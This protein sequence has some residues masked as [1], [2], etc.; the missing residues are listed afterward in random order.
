MRS[1]PIPIARGRRPR[2]RIPPTFFHDPVGVASVLFPSKKIC[3]HLRLDS[4]FF[5]PRYS[6]FDLPV[7]EALW[8][9]P[10]QGRMGSWVVADSPGSTTPGYRLASLRDA[11]LG[12]LLRIPRDSCPEGAR[13]G[14]ANVHN[15]RCGSRRETYLR[16]ESLPTPPPEGRYFTT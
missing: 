11:E 5:L 9:R 2:V 13:L 15:R 8:M 16:I 7:F 4:A 10:L 1:I 6:P 12:G 14:E 3:V